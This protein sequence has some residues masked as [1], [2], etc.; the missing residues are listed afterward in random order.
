[1]SNEDRRNH[2][3]V[4]L[5]LELVVEGNSGRHEARTIDIGVGGCY[6]DAMHQVLDGET[7]AIRVNLPSGEWVN[8][9]GVVLYDQWPTGFGIRFTEM[10]EEVEK[11]LD[12]VVSNHREKSQN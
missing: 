8:L 6:V 9:K 3:R 2:L 1:M 5:S 11:A 12:E 7:L 4:P 10:S